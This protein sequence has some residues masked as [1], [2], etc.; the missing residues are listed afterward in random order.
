MIYKP[1]FRKYKEEVCTE[2]LEMHNI[3]PSYW[4][5]ASENFAKDLKK[6]NAPFH[7]IFKLK[8]LKTVLPSLKPP[9]EKLLKSNVVYQIK[10]CR[11]DASYVWQT[12]QHLTT[13]LSEHKSRKGPVKEHFMLCKNNIDNDCITVLDSTPKSDFFLLTL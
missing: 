8:K 11:C 10:C 7:T 6:A 12:T 2:E 1:D 3:F 4:G 9:V 13:R 5:K